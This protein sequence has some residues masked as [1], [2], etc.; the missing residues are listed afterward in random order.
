MAKKYKKKKKTERRHCPLVTRPGGIFSSPDRDRIADGRLRR[1][2]R[3]RSKQRDPNPNPNAKI[4]TMQRRL[5]WPLRKDDTR[6]SRSVNN[7]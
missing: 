6:K 2:T 7:C 4:G 1:P 5:A 3:S